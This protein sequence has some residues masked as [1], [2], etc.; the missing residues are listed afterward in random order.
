VRRVAV[1]VSGGR[2]STA[3]LHCTAKAA[4]QLQLE[5]L[6]LHVHHGL[7]AQADDWLRHVQQ[8]SQRW[9]VGFAFQRLHGQPGA[10]ES[11]E[12]WAR[13]ERYAALA[14]LA[15]ANHCDLV[16]LAHHR[17]DQAETWLLQALRGGG[18]AS[19]SAMP[20]QR[21]DAGIH[22]CR[23]WLDQPRDR[24]D[25]YV[26]RHRLKHIEDSSNADPRFARNRLRLQV[27]PALLQAF[28]DAEQSLHDSATRAQEA[29]AL[30]EELARLDLPAVSD[31]QTLLV[32][33]WLALP[34]ARRLNALRAWLQQVLGRSG[35]QSLVER[36]SD[37][38][39]LRKVG[40]WQAPGARL[41]LYRG[42]LLA[43]PEPKAMAKRMAKGTTKGTT[44]TIAKVL[45]ESAAAAAAGLLHAPITL[46]LA[47]PGLLR[48]P[49][50][51]GHFVCT[52]ATEAGIAPTLLE[53]AQ[54]RARQGG[55]DFQ[56][57]A[58]SMARSLKKQYQ[59]RGV[60]AWHRQGPL[61]Y[62]AQGQLLFVPGLGVDGRAV[63][64]PGHLQLQ[65][66]WQGDALP[67]SLGDE[68]L[69]PVSLG[70]ASVHQLPDR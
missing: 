29:A 45:D 70:H 33:A 21:L 66:S 46:N 27:W 52:P 37:E 14:Q 57:S 8:Q 49:A 50:W 42:H 6:A 5:V 41:R 12:A 43:M 9:A 13:R 20:R 18:T 65:L 63:A 40:Q 24:I 11:V 48:V 61:L 17:R 51:G 44:K 60:P 38:L 59:A 68:S 69:G 31:A 56:F 64:A 47:T 34:P 26:R 7:N 1:A 2:D 4:A 3:L 23:P 58:N 67:K 55:E 53:A 15:H 16:L 10:G 22:W 28:P 62:S 54:A 39:R 35:P 25:A 36:L 19:L 32:P 30:A